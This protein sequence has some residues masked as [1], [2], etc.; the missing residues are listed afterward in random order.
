MKRAVIG[1]PPVTALMRASA[2]ARPS[3]VSH[4]V[5]QACTG[6]HREIGGV[7]VAGRGGERFHRR[8]DGVVVQDRGDGV[9]KD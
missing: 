2:H 7:L 5:T 1:S 8:R 9:E 4:E 6:Q 3:S